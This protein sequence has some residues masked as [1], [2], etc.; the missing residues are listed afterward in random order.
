MKTKLVVDC[1][2]GITTEV[3]LTEEEIYQLEI[4][5]KEALERKLAEEEALKAKKLIVESAKIKLITL[6][7]TEKEA[8][9]C[10]GRVEP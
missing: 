2:T 6:G 7:F 10:L 1:S 3:P 5:T 9:A 8:E 4:D